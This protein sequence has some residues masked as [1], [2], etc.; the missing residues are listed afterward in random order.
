[1]TKLV[2][3]LVSIR[4]CN[5]D[6]R[7][8]S[9]ITNM[10]PEKRKFVV[11]VLESYYV[12]YASYGPHNVRYEKQL[13][14]DCGYFTRLEPMDMLRYGQHD[15]R[16]HCVLCFS[17]LCEYCG[18]VMISDTR[19]ICTTCW[20]DDKNMICDICYDM[21]E[22]KGICLQCDAIFCKHISYCEQFCKKC[23][24]SGLICV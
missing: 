16:L 15:A 11:T 12:P 6:E 9:L 20:D 4:F 14:D 3:R 19:Y 17:Y 8:R 10:T 24:S 13:C 7:I 23:I 1:M 2:D 21:P 22:Y 18:Y 5:D